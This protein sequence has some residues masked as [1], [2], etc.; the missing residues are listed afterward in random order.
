MVEVQSHR[1]NHGVGQAVC[2]FA[3]LL[4]ASVAEAGQSFEVQNEK[5]RSH[6]L[7]IAL[8][9]SSTLCPDPEAGLAFELVRDFS[10]RGL[11]VVLTLNRA[12][13]WARKIDSRCFVEMSAFGSRAVECPGRHFPRPTH[14]AHD[15]GR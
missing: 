6:Y 12:F 8:L 1:I 3:P 10:R 11:A 9:I 13:E 7:A 15:Y 2:A 4:T 14:A 5:G